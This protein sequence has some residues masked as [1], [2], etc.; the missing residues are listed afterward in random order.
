[1][2]RYSGLPLMS[3]ELFFLCEPVQFKPGIKIYPPTVK[4][5]VA[6]EKFGQYSRLLTYSQEEV[7]DE[8]LEAKKSLEKYPTPFEF[9]LNNSYHNK[10]Y[11]QY[12]KEAFMF[13]I[14]E[15]VSF[16]YEQKTIIIG[17]I[18]EVL[19]NATSIDDLV[20]LK[21]EEFF[22]FQNILRELIGKKKVAKP[23]PNED[24]R[25]AEI[26]RKSRRAEKLK[27]K[28]S[29]KNKGEGISLYTTL[30]SICCMGLGITPLNIGEMS[31]VALEAILRKYQ[32]KEKYQLDIDSLLAGADSKKVK[33][34]YWIRNF[35]D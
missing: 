22:D 21:E 17:S 16:L 28:Q 29:A 9:L 2:N 12:C 5:V 8:F 35:E 1:M 25:I 23:N 7:E 31:Y 30:V 18:Q 27:A 15:E 26:K 24:P 4:D 10:Q 33:P 11:E 20:M 32:E 6:N 13:F 34:K 3:K 19:K 14:H